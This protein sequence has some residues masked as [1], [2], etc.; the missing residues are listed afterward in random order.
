MN[1]EELLQELAIKINTG[2]I[3][4]D[5]ILNKLKLDSAIQNED[6]VEKPK[7]SSFSITKMFYIV[8]AAII[9][10]GIIFFVSQIWNDIGFLG[11]ITVT[12][13]FGLVF[14]AFGSVLFK[15]KPNKSIGAIFH[16]IGGVLIPGGAMVALSEIMGYVSLW[17]A[18]FVFG[19]ILVF[20]LLL[21]YIHKK[22]ILTF[23][24]IAN[25][26]A[27]TYLIVEAMIDGSYYRHMDLYAYLTMI[28]GASYLLLAHVFRNDWNKGLVKILC[29]C[30]AT[31][32][33]S[34]AF[35]QV[36]N[37]TFWQLLYFIIVLGGFALSVFMKSRVILIM[38][39]IFLIIHISYISSEYFADS[40]GWPIL[41]VMLGFIFITLG[42]VSVNI[43]KKYITN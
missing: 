38:N 14:A 4:R 22:A 18:T 3:K 25:G 9:I 17:S 1:K 7:T 26:T 36:F 11:R 28:I 20:Y 15:S 30:G 21:N 12:L 23:F 35:S 32:F 41:L 19:I 33:L 13:G 24:A 34:A 31:G 43:S 8:G 5:E 6:E 37:S 29:F 27:F 2:E 40:L 10:I 39:T 42:Y 16:F